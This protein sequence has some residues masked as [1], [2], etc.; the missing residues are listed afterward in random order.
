MTNKELVKAEEI[1]RENHINASPIAFWEMEEYYKIS[2]MTYAGNCFIKTFNK[3]NK[4]CI[5]R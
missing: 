3:Q 1:L 5:W 4:I 2:Y